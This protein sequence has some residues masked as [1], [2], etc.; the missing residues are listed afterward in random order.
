MSS[1]LFYST[2]VRENWKKSEFFWNSFSASFLASGKSHSVGKCGRETLGVFE[3]PFFC[4]IE[5]K[6]RGTLLRHLKNL[7]KKVSQCQKPAQKNFVMGGTRTHVVL[8]GRP[9]KS[10]I[11]LYA[12][13][14]YAVSYNAYKICLFVGL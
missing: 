3:H 6:W 2:R 12:S 8:L 14:L 1:I 10:L 13:S 5:K 7:R 9:Q 4:K 11:E